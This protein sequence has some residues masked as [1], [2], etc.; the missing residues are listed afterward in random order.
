MVDYPEDTV[1][2]IEIPADENRFVLVLTASNGWFA[3]TDED[4]RSL[5]IDEAKKVLNKASNNRLRDIFDIE[6]MEKGD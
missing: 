2:K 3:L 5:E 6:K 4:W 1:L